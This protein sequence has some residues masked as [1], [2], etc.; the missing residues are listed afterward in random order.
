MNDRAVT[1]LSKDFELQLLRRLQLLGASIKTTFLVHI[2]QS[3][4]F[5][6]RQVTQPEE[7]SFRH[8]IHN[9]ISK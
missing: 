5:G 8:S 7:I 2:L 3:S 4:T 1:S 6:L 9:V